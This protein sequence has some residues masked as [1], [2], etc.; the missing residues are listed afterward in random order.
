MKRNL[1]RGTL[2]TLLIMTLSIFASASQTY[3]VK[4]ELWNAYEDTLS[5]GNN[6]LSSRAKLIV[7]GDNAKLHVT[8]KPL[9]LMGAKG[10]LGELV[11]EGRKAKVLSTYDAIDEYNDPDTG[12]DSKMKGKK[13]PK[14]L[15]F[16]VD[17]NKSM[18]N[19]EVY[20]PVMGE[21]GVGVQK[22]RIKITYP[23]DMN[24]AD[25]TSEEKT[26]AKTEETTQA[27]SEESSEKNNEAEEKGEFYYSVPVSLM[28]SVEDKES[29]GNASLA[30]IAN[31]RSKDGKSTIY[32]GSTQMELAGITAAMIN[33]YYDDG[34]EY[35][36]AEAYAYDMKVEGYDEPRPEVFAFPLEEKE[37]I[38]IM[39]DPKVEPMGDD[40]LKARIRLDLSK[41]KEI[42][43]ESASLI[44]KSESGSKKPEFKPEEAR[45]LKDKGF[46]LEVPEGA[47]EEKYTFY[48]NEVR[49]EEANKLRDIVVAKGELDMIKAYS[50]QTL[51][52]LDS[53][54]YDIKRPIND[55]RE[56]FQPKKPLKIS[57]L[58]SEKLMMAKDSLELMAMIPEGDTYKAE[59]I[60][61][62]IEG[63]YLKFS[64]DKLLPFLIKYK[65]NSLNT[66]SKETNSNANT[67][68]I[69]DKV[70][71]GKTSV[72]LTGN[73]IV[74]K[75]SP[76]LIFFFVFFIITLLVIGIY[77][78]IKYYRILIK[79]L[80]YGEQIKIELM[81]KYEKGGHK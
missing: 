79:E 19:C 62:E 70:N 68:K 12:T 38:N 49:G 69:E 35:K 11:V 9:D 56:H 32:L 18:M 67:E 74:E 1:L 76:E 78:S 54:A 66:L 8:M 29:M 3:D 15:E 44:L 40:P 36:K 41:K 16:P 60:D 34:R 21:M 52:E 39:I 65:N 73:K 48:G 24:K 25:N 37:Y 77:F 61:Y 2:L 33:L 53:I 22:A 10:Y 51:G 46:I 5:M 50:F 20:V 63:N 75:E 43:K 30:G 26:Q 31:I 13:Y 17:L 80:A 64:Y 81:K 27:K 55:S 7:D 14:V 6:G 45:I 47:F 58:L 71:S 72:I 28:H 57:I 42:K 4:V 23:K 59:K